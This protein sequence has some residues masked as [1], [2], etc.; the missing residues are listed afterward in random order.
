MFGKNLKHYRTINNYSQSDLAKKLYV[1]RQCVS[2]WEK[3][4]TQPDLETLEQISNLLNV[5]IDALV[6]DNTDPINENK[7]KTPLKLLIAN[8]LVALF[9]AVSFI[10]LWRFMPLTI[11]AHWT[12]GVSDRYGSRNEI[13]L[14]IVTAVVFLSLDIVIFFATKRIENKRGLY[15]AHVVLLVFQIAYLIFIV[16]LYAKYINEVASYVTA[17]NANL[18]LCMSVAIHPKIN[19]PNSVLGV[20]TYDT[21]KSPEIWNKTNSLACYLLSGTSLIILLLNVIFI[22]PLPYLF[23]TVYIL[24][25]IA[26]LIY[27]K[28][29]SKKMSDN[30]P[31]T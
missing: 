2:K 11:P 25:I 24:P 17:M 31:Q 5:S 12:N 26:V 28:I 3:G 1:T 6:K 10:V 7:N 19:E 18:L 30:A 23:L 20:R 16:V 8:V 4:V 22:L 21:L 13:F 9:C 29:I 15:I 14:H 27:S